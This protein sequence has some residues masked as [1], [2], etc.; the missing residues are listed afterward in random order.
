MTTIQNTKNKFNKCSPNHA[1]FRT[2]KLS[3]W[4]CM[5]Y[6][7]HGTNHC[8]SPKHVLTYGTHQQISPNMSKSKPGRCPDVPQNVQSSKRPQT[9]QNDSQTHETCIKTTKAVGKLENK[10]LERKHQDSRRPAITMA[11]QN[12]F[13]ST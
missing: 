6:Y 10:E 13:I 7:E 5:N 8:I 12:K 2:S 4:S 9:C 11:S 3:V 1:K